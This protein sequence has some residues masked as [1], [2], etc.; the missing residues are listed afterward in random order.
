MN[1]VQTVFVVTF[2]IFEYLDPVDQIEL[3]TGPRFG[4]RKNYYSV[5]Q[6][7]DLPPVPWNFLGV[8]PCLSLGILM[9]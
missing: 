1:C 9:A 5:V 4:N 7:Q 3:G 6:V 8:Y 2:V